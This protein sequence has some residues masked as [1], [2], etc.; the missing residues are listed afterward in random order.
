MISM[1]SMDYSPLF[2][3]NVSKLIITMKG[4]KNIFFKLRTTFNALNVLDGHEVENH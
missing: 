1:F 2:Q 3:Q 4:K